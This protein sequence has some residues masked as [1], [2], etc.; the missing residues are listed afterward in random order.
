MKSPNTYTPAHFGAN[1]RSLREAAGL[2]QQEVARRANISPSYLSRFESGVEGVAPSP[3]WIGRVT[4]VIATAFSEGAA[5]EVAPA[6]STPA[7]RGA[8]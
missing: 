5:A 6:D 7:L 2:S 1:I 3:E 4:Q 8:A